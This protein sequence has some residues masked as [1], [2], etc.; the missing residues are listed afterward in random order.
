MNRVRDIKQEIKREVIA[1]DG[2]ALWGMAAKS[3][4]KAGTKSIHLAN[5]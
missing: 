3:R 1:I 5:A 2:K 4:F